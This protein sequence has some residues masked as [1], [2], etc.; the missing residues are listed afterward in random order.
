M[1]SQCTCLPGQ[2]GGPCHDCLMAQRIYDLQELDRVNKTMYDSILPALQKAN[3]RIKQLEGILHKIAKEGA[4]IDSIAYP[5]IARLC[6]QAL[7]TRKRK[8]V[9]R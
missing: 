8:Q 7:H 3:K 6:Q 5:S 9:R 1:S 4:S 2:D